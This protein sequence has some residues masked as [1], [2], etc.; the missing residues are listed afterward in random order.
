[1]SLTDKVAIVTGSSKGIGR[2]IAL[3]LAS[4][5]A[6]VVVTSRSPEDALI[7]VGEIEK[8]G[9]RAA[10]FPF[11][12]ERIEGGKELVGGVVERFG[13]LDILVNNA[14][15]RPT[16][17]SSELVGGE[18]PG[19]IEAYVTTN[20]TRSLSLTMS[21]YPH[22]KK[23]GGSVLNIGSVIVNRHIKGTLMYAVV[24]GAVTQATKALASEWAGD[25]IRVNQINPG[26][27]LTDA[28]VSQVPDEEI[29]ERIVRGFAEKHPLGRVGD[30]SA[31]AILAGNILCDDLS[32]MTGSI[33]DVDGGYSVEGIE[34]PVATVA[35]G[36]KKPGGTA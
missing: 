8:Q 26:F 27:V 24:K 19:M 18:N 21:A 4:M 6:G 23:T 5:G 14:L 3:R 16:P 10:A 30:P 28:F 25:G 35:G 31:V 33:L 32:W 13:R 2:S 9:G 1:M 11:D 12:L 20:I 7:V 17:P 22:L 36:A 15:S 34:N 29:R